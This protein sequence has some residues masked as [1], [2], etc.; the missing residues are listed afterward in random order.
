MANARFL[1]RTAQEPVCGPGG[2]HRAR[3]RAG[4]L[5]ALQGLRPGS[6]GGGG[7]PP[8]RHGAAGQRLHDG[9]K[10]GACRPA[11]IRQH[12]SVGIE[13]GDPKASGRVGL[14]EDMKYWLDTEFIENPCFI[15]LISIGLVAEDGRE[16][17]A[18][19]SEVDWTKAS[20]WTE[21]I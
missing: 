6:A 13:K 4:L 2:I 14:G 5:G 18:E 21:Q 8:R 7:R 19:S 1:R 20:Q 11:G 9:A 10:T 12:G 17:Y 3:W 15:D 16:F